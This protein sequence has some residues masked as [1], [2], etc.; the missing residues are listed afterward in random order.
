M[1]RR[2]VCFHGHFYQPPRDSPWLEIV[3]EQPSARPAH[4]W[5]E[6]VTSECYRPN[7]HAR[8]LDG[9]GNV[10]RIVDNYE[11]IS[12]NFGPTLLSWMKD[13]DPALHDAITSADRRRVERT[14]HGSAM[15]QA[16][17]HAI[18]PLASDRDKRTHVRWGIADFEH[19]FGRKPKGMWLPETACDTASLEALAAE[20][21]T[22]TVLA[23]HQA[24]RVRP[25]GHPRSLDVTGAKV[26]T[27]RVYDVTLPSGRHIAIFFYDGP[28]SRSIAF[29]RVLDD[30]LRLRD[31]MLAS[32]DGKFD[33]QVS[34]VA[35]D[36]ETYGHHHRHGEMALAYAMAAVEADPELS[37]TTYEEMLALHPPSW[38]AEIVE[39]TSWSCAH[40]VERW[41]S[42]CGCSTGAE[43]GWK[44]QWR[45]PLR[46]ALDWLRGECWPRWREAAQGLFHDP[47]AAIDASIALVLDK[48]DEAQ[49]R[50]LS[51]YAKG[52]LDDAGEVRAL[53]LLELSRQLLLT[54]TSC[55][56]F[57]ADLTGIET[58]QNLRYAC[59]AVEL[60][61]ALFGVDLEPGLRARLALAKS[62]LPRL[63]TGAD[64]WDR[65][66]VTARVSLERA[67][68]HF[69]TASLFP[70]D[71]GEPPLGFRAEM[72]E[73]E[74]RHAGRAKLAW[75]RVRVSVRATRRASE[76]DFAVVHLGDHNVGGGVRPAR[77]AE[78][79]AAMQ[80]DVE[81]AFSVFDL[82]EVLRA[83]DR[84]FA[85]G[86]Y[87]L[88]SLFHDVQTRV[89]AEVIEQTRED[90]EHGL[91]AIH[92]RT[93]PLGR[94]LASLGQATPRAMRTAADYTLTARF[95][96]ALERD[97]DGV[98]DELSAIVTEAKETGAQLDVHE[99]EETLERTLGRLVDAGRGH[100]P[101]P[102]DRATSIVEAA[103]AG[104]L[105]LE[106]TELQNRLVRLRDGSTGAPAEFARAFARLARLLRVSARPAR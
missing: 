12:F 41:R 98:G 43:P 28:A 4:D 7:A 16:Y 37:L 9:E 90:V 62:N 40:G 38:E 46:A 23:P 86:T 31:R 32:L 10:E 89:I 65:D 2:Y 53:E 22:F 104:G 30:G 48:S 51:T 33:G 105:T 39:A 47:D 83:L 63:G 64:V 69:A 66:V 70:V 67:A 1:S 11:H 95:R 44:Q 78:E 73:R 77:S 21:I 26:D 60:A 56:W 79:L 94:Y 19:R 34:H 85:P 15:A 103:T 97:D 8:I 14:G 81:Q 5:N 82:T 29:E 80:R 25:I 27:R 72:V 75:G 59:R 87:S 68:A 20:G 100:D 49:D 18:L 50:F 6:R 17:G 102:L 99:I 74:E 36:G 93:A 3:E 35:T 101:A 54:D 92:E 57:F 106:L 52:P 13:A 61:E 55:A 88:R 58:I 76:F 42:D 84:H 96:R 91:E 45:A 24:N 71:G